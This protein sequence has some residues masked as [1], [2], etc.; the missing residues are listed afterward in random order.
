MQM[1]NQLHQWLFL[2][3]VCVVGATTGPAKDEGPIM[4]AAGKLKQKNGRCHPGLVYLIRD[5]LWEAI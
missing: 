2:L 1:E 4:Q 5:P 3:D